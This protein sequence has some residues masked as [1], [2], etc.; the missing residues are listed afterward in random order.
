MAALDAKS[1]SDLVAGTLD[2][3]GRMKFQQIAQDLTHYEVMGKWLK[4]GKVYYED[5][6]GIQKNLMTKLSNQAE[7]TGLLDTDDADIPDLMSQLTVPWRHAQTKWAFIYQEVLMNQGKS[8]V[9]NVI[10]PR[11]ADAMI[12]LAKELEAKAWASPGV[13]NVTEPYGI[14]YWV[15]PNATEGFNGGLPGSHT[16]KGGIDPS[17]DTNFKNWTNTYTNVTKADLI[18]SM[19]KGH[20]NVRWISPV[21]IEDY[22]GSLGE[23]CRVYTDETRITAFED[24]GEGQNENLGRDVAPAGGA[25]DV[26]F[27]DFTVTFR[28]HPI[29]WVPYL[30]DS[31]FTAATNPVYMIDHSV[32]NPVCLRG[33]FLRESP[34][35]KA[36]NQHNVFRVFVDLSYNYITYDLRRHA[37][38]VTSV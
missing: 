16:T 4:R 13:N 6:I 25:N 18:T 17:V 14:P 31:G 29:I 26:K 24:L 11:R 33:D 1:I 10:K 30:D 7:H 34:P 5:G 9:F 2:D 8:L 37:V 27:V 15:V 20:R 19:R 23:Q 3:L 21:T 22:R 38:F 36:P 32:F 35:E 28:K 12:S